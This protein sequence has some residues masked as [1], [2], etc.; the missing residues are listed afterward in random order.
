VALLFKGP[1]IGQR[2]GNGLH[3]LRARYRTH[4]GR[5]AGAGCFIRNT[6]GLK[7]FAERAIHANFYAGDDDMAPSSSL[8]PDPGAASRSSRT[9]SRYNFVA[10]AEITDTNNA[11]KLSGRVSEISRKGCYLDSLNSLPLGTEVSLF[12]SRD[13]G[14]FATQGKVIYVH[15]CI[16]MGIAFL[17][18]AKEQLQ[19]L[20][21]WLAEIPAAAAI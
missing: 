11:T 6:L 4:W 2:N 1:E 18:A 20:D 12:I 8:S 21:A 7:L 10:A 9:G 5:S 14:T 17:D 16:G 15:E 13:R 19:I 3:F